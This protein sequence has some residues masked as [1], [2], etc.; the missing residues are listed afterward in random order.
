MRKF[1][2][3]LL[4]LVAG[5][6]TAAVADPLKKGDNEL[7]FLFSY[8][9]TSFDTP[10]ADNLKTTSLD[11][12]WGYL[13]TD[14]FEAGIGLGYL[15]FDAGS[16]GDTDSTN[17]LPFFQYNFSTGNANPYIGVHYIFFSG[18]TGDVYDDGYGVDAG[19]K[20]Y[21]WSNGGFNFGVSWEQWNGAD[22][23]DDADTL[24]VGAGVLIK[25]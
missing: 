21:P 9:D 18:D 24:T 4:V 22:G 5:A 10:G 23:F 15:K 16:L 7:S 17:I 2:C 19:I 3:A 25:W 1:I 8:T 6:G 13:F 12:T 20:L 11:L 14:G